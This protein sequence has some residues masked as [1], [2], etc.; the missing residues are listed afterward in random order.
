MVFIVSRMAESLRGWNRCKNL[1]RLRGEITLANMTSLFSSPKPTRLLLFFLLLFASPLAAA[2]GLQDVGVTHEVTRLLLQLG[3]ILLA[4]KASGHLAKRLHMPALLG[5]V[6]VGVV[7][8]PYALGALPI[9]GFSDGLVPLAE[10]AFPIPLQLYAFAAVGAVIH[11]LVVGLESDRDLFSKSRRKGF[12]VAMGSSLLSLLAGV[13]FGTLFMGFPLLD[14]RVF[15]LAALS[16]STSLGVQAR[17]LHA[18]NQMASPEGA[19]V[20]SASLL[21]D[22][23]AIVFLAIAMAFGALELGYA[24]DENI[25]ATVLPVTLAAMGVLVMGT[26]FAVFAAPRMAKMLREWGNPNIFLVFVLA[27]A[28]LLSGIFE[29]FGVAAIIGAYIV[30]ISFSLTDMGDVLAEKSQPVSE[31]FVP[32]LYVVMG[33]LVDFRVLLDPAIILPGLGFAMLSGGAKILGSAAPALAVG[34]SPWGSLR[35]G[36][37]TVTRGEVALIIASVGLALGDFSLQFFQVMVVM[38]VV[39][40]ALGAPLFALSLRSGGA[41]TRGS[42]GK[43]RTERFD[44]DLP[45]EEITALITD[46]I[47]KVAEEDGFFVHRLE[48]AGTVYRLRRDEIYL[49]INKRDKGID[50]VCSPEDQGIAKTLLYEVIVHVRERMARLTEIHVPEELR[51]DV[52]A[53]AGS[54]TLKLEDFLVPAQVIIPLSS[55]NKEGII[56]ELVDCLENAGRLSDPD[57][58]LQDVMER[59]ASFSTGMDHG[60]AIP[61]GRSEGIEGMALA[62]GLVPDGVDFQSLDGQPTRIVFLIATGTENRQPHL[63]LLASI[64]K[65]LREDEV[66]ENLLGAKSPEDF[67]QIA[68]GKR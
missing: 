59:E 16:V 51:R 19:A 54:G 50:I 30:G 9:P 26:L 33:M 52:A 49:T 8:S 55:R 48:L 39:S 15:F 11:V 14:R 27:F 32:V 25:W 18:Q 47:M 61:H 46:G 37:G 6:S 28:L 5:E 4:A 35:V 45:N 60:L 62:A 17:I 13:V 21:Q 2:D 29:V 63:Q 56:R 43:S 1:T 57:R 38:I 3:I 7:L 31:F 20:V 22:G 23:F 40:V 10:G 66:R 64:A 41:G 67:V 53:G 44:L 58:V 12:A 34:F 24:A 42:W 68:L 65:T 36:L